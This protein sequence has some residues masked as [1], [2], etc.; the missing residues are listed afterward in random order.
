[1]SENV[2]LALGA[3]PGLDA[4]LAGHTHEVFPSAQITPAPGIDAARGRLNGTPAVM[5]GARGSHL[6]VIDLELTKS[7]GGAWQV[8]NAQSEARPLGQDTPA[9]P[10]MTRLLSAAHAKTLSLTS[11]PLGHTARPLH[12][13]LALVQPC[14]ATRLVT[15]AKRMAAQKLVAGTDDAVYPILSAS[16]SFKTGGRAGPNHYTDVP[17]GPLC[18][19]HAADLYSFPN[20]LCMLRL[21]GADLRDW[22]ERAAIVF[23]QVTPGQTCQR[24]LNPDVPGHHFDMID[25]LSYE[26]DL[27]QPPRYDLMG[28]LISD[29]ARRIHGLTYQGAPLRDDQTFVLVTNN[30][31]A[32]GGGPFRTARPEQVVHTSTRILRDIVADYIRE[33]GAEAD[34]LW[35]E[36]A[37]WHFTSMPNTTVYFDTGP[38]LRSYPEEIA[39]LPARD[40]GDSPNG[41]ARLELDLR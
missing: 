2:A 4:I 41:F 20:V 21:T 25:G 37:Q 9:S 27:S 26:I 22:L 18:L 34:S 6:G 7:D 15:R 1:M 5:A 14:A 31:R 39:A 30:Y 28:Q 32:F 16:A 36:E 19:R 35:Q 40:M 11:V 3:L 24:L 33:M 13:Y 17:P 8:T 38:G 12:S 23:E 10:D 29:K